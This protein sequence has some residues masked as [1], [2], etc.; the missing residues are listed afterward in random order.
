MSSPTTTTEQLADARSKYH[1]LLTGS[2]R[3]TVRDGD[4]TV[5][6]TQANKSDLKQYI[7]ELE[8]TLAAEQGTT[9]RVRRTPIGV[10][11]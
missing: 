10:I 11:F 4:T 9:T 6:Y 1:Q 3:V 2:L 5:E 8:D 7:I